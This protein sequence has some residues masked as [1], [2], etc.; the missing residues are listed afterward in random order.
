MSGKRSESEVEEA[1]HESWLTESGLYDPSLFLDPKIGKHRRIA[2]GSGP[3]K[4]LPT[5]HVA[6]SA[7]MSGE[8]QPRKQ[9]GQGASAANKQLPPPPPPAPEGAEETE[10]HSC[11]PDERPETLPPLSLDLGRVGGE[12][13][14]RDAK[15]GA[16]RDP[17]LPSRPSEGMEEEEGRASGCVTSEEVPA[18]R[19]EFDTEGRK[20]PEGRNDHSVQQEQSS[21]RFPLC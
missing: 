15:T 16:S 18:R 14:S 11:A 21:K 20:K 8:R 4:T 6:E 10:V 13:D 2:N 12:E 7:V 17:P 5:H 19:K 3:P 1:G 9:R